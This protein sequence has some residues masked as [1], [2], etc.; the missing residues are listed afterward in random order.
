M[1]A[2]AR[3]AGRG[4]GAMDALIA[5]TCLVCDLVLATRNLRDF[6]GLGVELFGPWS[7]AAYRCCP[8]RVN[9]HTDRPEGGAFAKQG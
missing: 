1:L 6:D 2:R 5:A 4:L 3:Q 8:S 9:C 7:Q